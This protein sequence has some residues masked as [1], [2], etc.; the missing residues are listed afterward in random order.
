M[1]HL[2]SKLQVIGRLAVVKA[3]VFEQ[4]D[5]HPNRCVQHISLKEPDTNK[6]QYSQERTSKQVPFTAYLA[7]LQRCSPTLH[8]R[9]DAVPYKGHL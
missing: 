9:T 2:S 8:L 7:R 4:H 5:L 3:R 6:L 1:R